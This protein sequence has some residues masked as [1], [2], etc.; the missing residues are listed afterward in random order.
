MKHNIVLVHYLKKSPC[1][2]PLLKKSP[3]RLSGGSNIFEIIHFNLLLSTKD[4]L[5]HQHNYYIAL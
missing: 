4:V 2:D 3:C 1:F 5:L